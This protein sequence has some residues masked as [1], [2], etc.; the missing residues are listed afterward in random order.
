MEIL[1][2]KIPKDKK[3]MIDYIAVSDNIILPTPPS[4]STLNTNSQLLE[5]SYYCSKSFCVYT[6]H[7]FIIGDHFLISCKIKLNCTLD[8]N[9]TILLSNKRL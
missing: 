2:L 4:T 1:P 5:N 6:D 7:D 3:S 8:N 9:Q